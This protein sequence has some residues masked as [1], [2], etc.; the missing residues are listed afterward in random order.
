ME[1][2]K[3]NMPIH[4]CETDYL[5]VAY[6]THRLQETVSRAGSPLP[7]HSIIDVSVESRAP[8]TEE[9]S[10]RRVVTFVLQLGTHQVNV[11]TDTDGMVTSV[12][13]IENI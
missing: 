10:P 5:A 13:P 1:D 8:Q 11:L 3:V 4:N 7:D 6:C 2:Y 12:V 9:T